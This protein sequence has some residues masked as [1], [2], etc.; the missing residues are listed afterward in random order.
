M[1]IPLGDA[2]VAPP[3][4]VPA[5][6]A[7]AEV[8]SFPDGTVRL[9]F[10]TSLDRA[11]G[12]PRFTADAVPPSGAPLGGHAGVWSGSGEEARDGG[13]GEGT[14]DFLY[15]FPGCGL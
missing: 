1:V 3:T 14:A 6:V 9:P 8:A 4:A 11:D 10:R 12:D 7:A 13:E 5:E 2:L 15:S